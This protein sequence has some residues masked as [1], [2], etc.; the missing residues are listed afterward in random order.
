MKSTR[1]FIVD[2]SSGDSNG[3]L[4]RLLFCIDEGKKNLL[5]LSVTL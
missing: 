5:G 1:S 2:L 4:F 3:Y